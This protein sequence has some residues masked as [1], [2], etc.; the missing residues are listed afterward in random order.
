MRFTAENSFYDH[1]QIVPNNGADVLCK[2]VACRPSMGTIKAGGIR[3]KDTF[4]HNT[5]AMNGNRVF[6]N[7]FLNGAKSMVADQKR[8]NRKKV[9]V[10]RKRR[11]TSS[12]NTLGR[13]GQTV[14]YRYDVSYI[15]QNNSVVCRIPK[16]PKL[17]TTYSGTL[18]LS[19]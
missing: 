14:E 8:H 15:V 12:V 1:L 11:K 7:M 3:A 19:S 17:Q 13:Q 16:I 9:G 18:A 10:K 6:G 5:A 2:R 4:E